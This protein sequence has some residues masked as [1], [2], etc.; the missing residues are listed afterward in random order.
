MRT[1]RSQTSQTIF[2]PLGSIRRSF[3]ELAQETR[4]VCCCNAFRDAFSYRRIVGCVAH[5]CTTGS[6]SIRNIKC[7]ALW[8]ACASF[9]RVRFGE[10]L[11]RNEQSRFEE[12]SSTR[13]L[14]GKVK[15][16][17]P[18]L[19]P[20]HGTLEKQSSFA[21][22]RERERESEGKRNRREDEVVRG[23]RK[24]YGK[25]KGYLENDAPVVKR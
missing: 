5:V 17:P 7:N 23:Q 21:M 18:P 1:F 12:V 22:A 11:T 15:V 16:E 14:K 6:D 19:A 25:E 2:R 13:G 24:M 8:L 9:M 3:I 10:T 20:E 4:V